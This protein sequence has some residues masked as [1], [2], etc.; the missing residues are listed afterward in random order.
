MIPRLSRVANTAF[1]TPRCQHRVAN[2]ALCPPQAP[3][4][5]APPPYH[6]AWSLT[7][8]PTPVLYVCAIISPLYHPS[9]L[10]RALHAPGSCSTSRCRRSTRSVFTGYTRCRPRTSR[11][12]RRAARPR[13]ARVRGGRQGGATTAAAGGSAPRAP[14]R[15]AETGTWPCTDQA[16]PQRAAPSTARVPRRRRLARTICGRCHGGQPPRPATWP[17]SRA[18]ALSCPTRC[19]TFLTRRARWGSGWARERRSTSCM[20]FCVAATDREQKR[21][22]T[23]LKLCTEEPEAVCGLVLTKVMVRWAT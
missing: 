6:T 12:Q 19:R 10:L 9:P 14:C 20:L 8:L 2:T 4:H 13:R 17:L 15:T 1:P 5:P 22:S 11:T 21:Q 23:H 7:Y 16:P 3:S 18:R